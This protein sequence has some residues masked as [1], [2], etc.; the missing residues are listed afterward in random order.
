MEQQQLDPA[1]R[2]SFEAALGSGDMFALF[3]RTR[4]AIVKYPDDPDVRYLQALAM[5]RLGDPDAAL[6]LYRRNRVD[7]IGTEDAIA[8]KGRIFKDLAAQAEGDWQVEL[9]RQASQAYRKA[10]EIS[11][12]YYSG[13][14]AA[15]TALLA[16]DEVTGIVGRE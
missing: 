12:G 5:A 7:R 3:E 9:F 14:N 1:L 11:D 8:L 4:A 6:R 15:T 2:Q 13:I 10:F 16:G